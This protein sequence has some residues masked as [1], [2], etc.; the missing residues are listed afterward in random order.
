MSDGLEAA[1]FERRMLDSLV[2]VPDVLPARAL[3][4]MPSHVSDTLR[5]AAAPRPLP[6]LVEIVEDPEGADPGRGYRAV[7]LLLRLGAL[8]WE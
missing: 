5:A 7:L 2:A 3:S 1:T 6:E 8:H 4:A